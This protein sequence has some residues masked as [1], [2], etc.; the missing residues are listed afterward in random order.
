MDC[1]FW[2]FF[3]LWTAPFNFFS[4]RKPE[5]RF[6][7]RQTNY[8]IRCLPSIQIIWCPSITRIA[9]QASTSH[10]VIC[11]VPLP[12]SS[13]SHHSESHTVISVAILHR[14]HSP[15]VRPPFIIKAAERWLRR[16]AHLST[17]GSP[18]SLSHPLP[19][20]LYASHLRK[21]GHDHLC[22]LHVL[23]ARDSPLLEPFL[24]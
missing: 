23:E 21:C 5:C 13:L 16:L 1:E 6:I 19:S 20:L 11:F 4:E 15:C 8:L 7:E 17:R 18:P 12:A 3:L 2:L 22:V 14:R 24:F 10:I 9:P